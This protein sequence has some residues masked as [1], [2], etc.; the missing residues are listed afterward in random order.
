MHKIIAFLVQ[1]IV[2]STIIVSACHSAPAKRIMVVDS[3]HKE[4]GWSKQTHE[5]FRQALNDLSYFDQNEQIEALEEH[6]FI[7]TSQ[8]IIQVLWMDSK[9]QKSASELAQS[10]SS[11]I[12]KISEFKP[13]LIFLGEDNALNHIGNQLLDLD[14][15]VVFWGV[16]NTPVKYGLVDSLEKPG[17]NITGVYQRPYVLESLALLAAIKP[18]IKSFALLSD[19]T[20]TSRVY[21]KTIIRLQH[22]GF[23]PI[24]LV[25]AVTT[26]DFDFF[27]KKALELQES[28]DAF[29]ISPLVGMKGADGLP[30]PEAEVLKWYV[31]NIK[32]PETTANIYRVEK[33]LLCAADDSAFKQG[34]VAAEMGHEILT[35]GADPALMPPRAPE[36]GALVVN[37][38]RA[39]ML[40]LE[41][42]DEMGIEKY[43]TIRKEAEPKKKIMVVSSYHPEYGWSQD[44]N[45][46]FS[47]A[48]LELGYFENQNQ[49]DIFTA[50]DQVETKK[51]MLKK[52]WL[53]S[54]LSKSDSVR[55]ALGTKVYK[56]IKEFGPDLILLGDDNAARIIGGDFL[57]TE[58]PVV[59]WGVNS[60]PVKYGL[61]DS[62]ESP[63]H[64]VTGVYQVG[65]YRQSM[66]FLLKIVPGIKTFALLSDAGPTARAHLKAVTRFA[67]RG[68][69][70][71][72]IDS[73]STNDY[74]F[75][76]KRALELQSK[77]DAFFVAPYSGLKYTDGEPVPE[78]VVSAWYLENIK[79]PETTSTKF[80]VEQGF[81]CAANDSG[82][83]Q[84]FEAVL[85]AHDILS[86][87]AY[88]ATYPPRTVERGALVCN[89][90][91]AKALGLTLTKEMGIE[92]FVS[93]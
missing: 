44:T 76:K 55:E 84:G 1:V 46:G 58:I 53:H 72:L 57:D 16:N 68:N 38:D 77:V 78:A 71:K 93:P 22:K 65:Y 9:H 14:V 85:I 23:S 27:K 15:P 88:P 81:L 31:N 61:V 86:G 75:W 30:V 47:K 4:Y 69:L 67:G 12:Q 64:N 66:E 20:T 60:T 82:F 41:L 34:Y 49:A 17:H 42:T 11:I 48:M 39:K 3:Y 89:L 6:D 56:L 18:T 8:A 35:S 28:V 74:E 7:A 52:Y 79:I 63:G 29:F 73:V 32:I 21:A 5:G 13:D 26:N 2:L 37:T 87:R 91:R 62:K 90:K 50:E 45:R 33:G 19:D 10:T 54:K 51:I 25:E 40:G 92:E 83:K 70:P 36:R 59:F 80:R 24:E 43:V